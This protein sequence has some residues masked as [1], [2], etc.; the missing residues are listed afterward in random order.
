MEF[1]NKIKTKGTDKMFDSV[2]CYSRPTFNL[3]TSLNSAV[4]LLV[5]Y[6]I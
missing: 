2:I 6:F 3:F 5:I 1:K 4:Q